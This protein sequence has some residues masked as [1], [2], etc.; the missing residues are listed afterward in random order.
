MIRICLANDDGP[1]G[2]GLEVLADNLSELGEV[3]V[4]VPDQ[5][6]SGSG[7]SMTLNHPLRITETKTN[8][9]L[10]MLKHSG[11]PADSVVIATSFFDDIDIFV[12]GINAGA[13]LGYQSMMTSGTVG[14]AMEAAILGYPSVAVS[15]AVNPNEWFDNHATNRDY[16]E[17]SKIATCIIKGV[18]DNGLPEGIDALNI[19]F[20]LS[21]NDNP[22]IIAAKPVRLRMSNSLE[23]R[24][25]PNQSTYYWI[26]GKFQDIPERTDAYIV[27]VE[28]NISVSPIVIETVKDEEV[29][30]VKGFLD[31]LT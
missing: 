28:S 1:E 31:L 5:Q 22:E 2:R 10:T 12:A 11:K 14:I 8:S 9:G 16:A 26:D 20:P 6:R 23:Q 7:K 3:I 4:V 24:T 27:L 21:L 13:N 25:D 30:R 29:E 18:I 17:M 19:N 15:M